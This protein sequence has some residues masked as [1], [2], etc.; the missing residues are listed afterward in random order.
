MH[1]LWGRHILH[2][3]WCHRVWNLL[4]VHGWLLFE[5]CWGVCIRVKVV[6]DHLPEFFS[7]I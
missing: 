5:F 6:D 4:F 3:I 2:S 7:P 1:R